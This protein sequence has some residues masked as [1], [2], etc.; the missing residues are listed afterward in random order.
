MESIDSQR[1][2]MQLVVFRIGDEAFGVDV[3]EVREIIR[4]GEIT[5]IPNA[6]HYIDG[7]INLRSRITVVMNLRKKIGLE[8][9]PVDGNS[10][11]IIL[12]TCDNN[13]GIVV[14]SVAEVKYVSNEQIETLPAMMCSSVDSDCIR[15]V[16]KL[17]DQ[18][19][20]LI[21][22]KKLV[23]SSEINIIKT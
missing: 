19:L 14:D 3:S 6:P 11:I 17:P 8:S 10:R 16:C 5:S 1:P 4:V 23:M 2:D 7:I 12:E 21:D 9:K 22:L 20:I 15:G 13:M 18:L